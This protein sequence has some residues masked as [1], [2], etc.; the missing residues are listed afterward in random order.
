MLSLSL[1]ISIIGFIVVLAGGIFFQD[2]VIR[3]YGE[4]SQ[5]FVNYYYWIFP[6]SL[7]LTLYNVL[8]AYT[9]NLHKS[10][11]TNF[12]KEVEWRFIITILIVLF[13]FRILPDYSWFVKGFSFSY[14]AIAFTLLVYL[15]YTRKVH[16]IF[17]LSKVTLRFKKNIYRFV[18]LFLGPMS[19]LP[20][21]RLLT[22]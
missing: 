21:R 6:L 14:L 22:L 3:K 5:L 15:L 13:I 9:W 10:I 18:V 11:V 4:N 20:S 12:V 1:F 16:F 19:F 8:E 17:S 2:L 7:G